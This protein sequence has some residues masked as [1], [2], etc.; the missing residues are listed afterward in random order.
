MYIK[1]SVK[2]IL[3]RF[4]LYGIGLFPEKILTSPCNVNLTNTLAF[5]LILSRRKVGRGHFPLKALTKGQS[6]AGTV[7]S[8]LT[9]NVPCLELTIANKLL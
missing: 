3:R 1:K 8:L 9:E 7:P 5:F 2:H 4:L 6:P